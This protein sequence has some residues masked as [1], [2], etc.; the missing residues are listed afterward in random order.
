MEDILVRSSQG[1]Y[2]AIS[3]LKKRQSAQ[4]TQSSYIIRAGGEDRAIADLRSFYQ[5]EYTPV[6]RINQGLAEA[7]YCRR[8]GMSDKPQDITVDE[9]L[10]ALAKCKHGKSTGMDGVPYELIQV[11]MQSSH[12]HNVA[13]FLTEV[14]N[15]ERPTPKEWLIGQISLLPKKPEPRVPRD[16]RPICLSAAMGKIYTKILW[17]RIRQHCNDPKANQ[18]SECQGPKAWMELLRCSM[19]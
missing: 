5:K 3:Y 11:F 1:D 13:K 12:A 15:D 14:L 10:E 16:L 19:L 8:A 18:L 4:S 17:M 2:T 6:D 9:I 7:M